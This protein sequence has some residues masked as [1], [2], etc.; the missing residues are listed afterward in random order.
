MLRILHQTSLLRYTS[1][2]RTTRWLLNI[3]SW[4]GWLTLNISFLM[5]LIREECRECYTQFASPQQPWSVTESQWD[6]HVDMEL[7]ARPAE[8]GDQAEDGGGDQEEAEGGQGQN[9]WHLVHPGVEPHFSEVNT[10]CVICPA[11]RN[12][13]NYLWFWK[14]IQSIFRKTVNS[15][16]FNVNIFIFHKFLRTIFS[17]MSV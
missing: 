2:S 5:L 9:H 7:G 15:I 4:I 3:N 1:V 8:G 17:T 6:K 10:A 14:S 13:M 16:D 12:Y 11:S